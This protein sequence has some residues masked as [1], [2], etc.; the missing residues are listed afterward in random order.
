[1]VGGS[2]VMTNDGLSVQPELQSL[3]KVTLYEDGSSV[4][5][6]GRLSGV[7]KQHGYLILYFET[8]L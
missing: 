5:P 4:Y 8:E 2:P 6:I 1:M 3:E 7:S